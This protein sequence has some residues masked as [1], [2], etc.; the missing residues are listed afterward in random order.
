M[1]LARLILLTLLCTVTLRNHFATACG[2]A[3]RYSPSTTDPECAFDDDDEFPPDDSDTPAAPEDDPI[4]SVSDWGDEVACPLLTL[5]L[6]GTP[7]TP[8][9]QGERAP[10]AIFSANLLYSLRRLR[11]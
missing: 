5:P 7:S 6:I 9:F 11:L 10:A 1:F 2:G 3:V 4:L 8:A